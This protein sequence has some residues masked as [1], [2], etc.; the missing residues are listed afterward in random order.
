M[1]N[2]CSVFKANRNDKNLE[3]VATP[4]FSEKNSIIET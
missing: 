3:G 4:F 1:K 2:N